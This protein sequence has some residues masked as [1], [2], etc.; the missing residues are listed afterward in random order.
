MA[1]KHDRAAAQE[2][3]QYQ[4][5]LSAIV[6]PKPR[7]LACQ[8]SVS[9]PDSLQGQGGSQE[10][11]S[12]HDEDRPPGDMLGRPPSLEAGT[13]W[14]HSLQGHRAVKW[15]QKRHTASGDRN[16]QVLDRDKT[17]FPA[18]YLYINSV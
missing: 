13:S 12:E 11:T 2:F 10:G 5:K 8:H 7:G 14:P 15:Q 4:P 1:K 3:L 6:P 9:P 17:I 18:F 16:W